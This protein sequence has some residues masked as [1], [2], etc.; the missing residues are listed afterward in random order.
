MTPD[1]SKTHWT[2]AARTR[3]F[4]VPDEA[5]LA[6][7]PFAL[8][9]A[10]GRERSVDE[11]AVA[12]YEVTEEEA[13]EWAREQLGAVF[14]ELRGQT[15]DFVARLKQKTAEMREENRRTWEQAVAD[16]PPEVREAGS[17]LRDMLKD[18]GATLRRAAREHGY[19]PDAPD[20]AD[21]APSA[22]ASSAS[23]SASADSAP[24]A[25]FTASS[26]SAAPA[27][28]TMSAAADFATSATPSAPVDAAGAAAWVDAKASAEANVSASTE[29]T[30]V[31][32]DAPPAAVSPSAETPAVDADAPPAAPPA[33]TETTV[34]ADAPPA[35]PPADRPPS[36]IGGNATPR[37][38]APAIRLRP[39]P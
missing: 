20:P 16:A 18:L 14:G 7:G 33:S 15:L 22:S 8:R 21:A 23:A 6:P 5:E 12:P 9:T 38:D 35:P 27:G 39:E 34:D 28:S 29:R 32:A 26:D 19:N 11:S 36:I 37:V 10:A 30:M 31:D 25:D 13:R 2:D 3:H 4:I 17:Q 1:L 24:P